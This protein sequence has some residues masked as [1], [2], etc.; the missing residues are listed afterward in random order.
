[1]AAGRRGGNGDGDEM[2]ERWAAS[3]RGTREDDLCLVQP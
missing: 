2:G 1:M 3:A